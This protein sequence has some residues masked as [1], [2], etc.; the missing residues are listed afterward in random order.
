MHRLA[1][2]PVAALAVVG[3]VGVGVA[4]ANSTLDV[5][6]RV[7][8]VAIVAR[9]CSLQHDPDPRAAAR[10]LASWCAS[11]GSASG[12]ARRYGQV[13]S[14]SRACHRAAKTTRRTRSPGHGRR[15]DQAPSGHHGPHL[16]G[17]ARELAGADPC[18]VQRR[19]ADHRLRR[20]TFAIRYRGLRDGREQLR[21]RFRRV[22]DSGT[23]QGHR[24]RLRA[25]HRA[26]ASLELDAHAHPR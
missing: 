1:P 21:D 5:S 8:V 10:S 25:G 3:C 12:N 4:P 19:H 16:H 26:R 20:A 11:I 2:P 24:R 15:R 23:R 9:V 18:L 17:T 14:D 6:R 22:A 13:D 7:H